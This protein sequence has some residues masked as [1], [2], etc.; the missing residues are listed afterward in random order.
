MSLQPSDI[1]YCN[2]TASMHACE[3]MN[4]SGVL[5]AEALS[6]PNAKA[7]IIRIGPV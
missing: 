2:N 7:L 3:S 1:Q 6:S 4:E 5:V